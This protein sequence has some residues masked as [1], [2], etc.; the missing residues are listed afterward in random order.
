MIEKLK[1]FFLGKK[2]RVT[3]QKIGTFTTR[4]RSSDSSGSHS[5]ATELQLPR[6]KRTALL[7]VEG[8][9]RGPFPAQLDAIHQI[10]DN[11]DEIQEQLVGQLPTD[12][13]E[14]GKLRA[15]QEKWYLQQIYPLDVDQNE[16]DLLFEAYDPENPEVISMVW[17]N[18]QCTWSGES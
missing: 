8:N 15:W 4:I 12:H 1:D 9:A 13:P 2:V 18:G 11:L 17:A 16:F 14:A 5:W 6:Q 3:D 10:M 7:I